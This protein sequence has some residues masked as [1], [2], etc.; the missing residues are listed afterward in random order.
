MSYKNFIR[1]LNLYLDGKLSKEESLKIK[2]HL[3]KCAQ[4][5]DVYLKLLSAK[6]SLGVLEKVKAGKN[7]E[8]KVLLKIASANNAHSF[9]HGLLLAAKTSILS[10]ALLFAVISA[11]NFFSTP[12]INRN[13][14]NI[15]HMDYYVL[16]NAGSYNKITNT[17]IN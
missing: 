14:D 4:C 16:E 12:K 15:A 3:K 6:T 1:N 7:F 17:F 8:S 11:F 5:S 10:A 13:I 9:S 2:N